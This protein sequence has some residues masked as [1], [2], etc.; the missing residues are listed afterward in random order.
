MSFYRVGGAYPFSV[1]S[2]KASPLD[3]S[4]VN[5][6]VLVCGSSGSGKSYFVSKLFPHPEGLMLFKPDNIFLSS[7]FKITFFSDTGLP[8]LWDF[9]PFDVADAYLYALK[10]DNSGIMA[11]S[12]I[13]VLVDALMHCTDTNNHKNLTSFFD[14][15]GFPQNK[16]QS[17]LKNKSPPSFISSQIRSLI[18]SHFSF[19]YS[20]FTSKR[21]R[22]VKDPKSYKGLGKKFYVSFSGLGSLRSEFGAELVLRSLYSNLSSDFGTLIIDEFHHVARPN[23]IVDTLLREFRI[24]GQ[25]VAISQSLSDISS[26]IL[27]NFGTILISRSIHPQDLLYLAS[28]NEKLPHLVSSLPPFVFLNLSAFLSGSDKMPLYRWFNDD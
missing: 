6:H 15:L 25:L 9:K 8:F 11:S 16:S 12:L 14:Y 27:A 17:K 20:S 18:Y 19:F 22:P 13:P 24:S 7:D 5:S 23:S 4:P 3:F 28:L 1:K 21:G 26:S 2:F 10:I